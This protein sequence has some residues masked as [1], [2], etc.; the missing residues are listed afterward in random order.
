MSCAS[1]RTKPRPAGEFAPLARRRPTHALV[2]AALALAPVLLPTALVAQGEGLIFVTRATTTGTSAASAAGALPPPPSGGL[3]GRIFLRGRESRLELTDSA[4]PAPFRPGSVL[5]VLD[6]GARMVVLDTVAHAYYRLPSP[7]LTPAGQASPGAAAMRLTGAEAHVEPLGPGE[8][9]LGQRTDRWRLVGRFTIAVELAGQRVE[10]QT[11]L[12]REEW[13]GE[14][15]VDAAAGDGPPLA[16]L[17]FAAEFGATLRAATRQLPHRLPLRSVV[18]T[19][20]AQAGTEVLRTVATSEVVSLTRGPIPA[21]AFA[22]PAG[23]REVPFPM[24][25]AR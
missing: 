21:G 11:A 25:P 7:G 1:T 13:Y 12:T 9:L 22:I 5:L 4:P 24:P 6:G 3:S 2:R 10:M 20:V 17:P 23:Y 18:T 15:A 14:V 8:P 19:V 16:D